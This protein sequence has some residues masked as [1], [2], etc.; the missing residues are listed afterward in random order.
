MLRKRRSVVA[1]ALVAAIVG[2]AAYR[3]TRHDTPENQPP[4]AYLESSTLPSLQADFNR[5][6]NHSRIILLLSPT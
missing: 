1:L 3:L 2:F 6:T 5:F 4:L